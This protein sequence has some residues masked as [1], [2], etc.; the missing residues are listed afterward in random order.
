MADKIA[1]RDAYGK[2]L[3]KLGEQDERVVVLD[4]DLWTSTRTQDFRE[5]YPER[6][7]DA[8]IAE[9]NMIG[10]AAGLALD[11]KIPFVSSFACF[12]ARGW[13]QFRVSVGIPQANVKLAFTHGGLTVGEDGASAQMLEDIA[14]WRVVPGIVVIVPADGP[15]AEQATYAAAR[16]VGPV[17]I[18]L[19]R[20]KEPIVLPDDYQ[21]EIGKSPRLREGGDVAIAA[22]GI[23]VGRAL[24]A[25]EQLAADGIEATVI[26]VS[27]IKPIDTETL[28]DAARQ[29]G[30][31]V[32]AEEHEI[33]GGMGSAVAEALAQHCPVPIE[34]VGVRDTYGESGTPDELLE[35]Y[36]L[37][38]EAVAE[39]ARKAISRRDAQ[40]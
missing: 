18:R 3:L 27:T 28:A 15:E 7:I 8:G 35:K 13:E 4:A 22:C 37:T 34:M 5:T 25:A 29:T 19:G 11:G 32:T 26:D 33:H 38:G 1:T 30:A 10:V 23:M 20:S 31:V 39:A 12:G 40:S 14:L 6:F 16:H 17:Y 36:G 2:A 21:F 24:D 9:Q